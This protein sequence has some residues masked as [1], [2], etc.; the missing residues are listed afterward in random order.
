MINCLLEIVENILVILNETWTFWRQPKWS[1]VS[2]YVWL[3]VCLP[4]C[5]LVCPRN[6]YGQ[7]CFASAIFLHSHS[8]KYHWKFALEKGQGSIPKVQLFFYRLQDQWRMRGGNQNRRKGEGNPNGQREGNRVRLILREQN[9]NVRKGEGNP[10]GRIEEFGKER[11]YEERKGNFFRVSTSALPCFF[12]SP[13][14]KLTI[15]VGK[16]RGCS[17][18]FQAIQLAKLM[19][20]RFRIFAHTHAQTQ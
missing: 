6:I 1:T 2:D 20:S 8:N 14:W 9:S 19:V 12:S 10:N 17:S 15:F 5:M 16:G 4:P 7:E 3:F 11:M 13:W 18:N